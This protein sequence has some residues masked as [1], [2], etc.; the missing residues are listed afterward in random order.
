MTVHFVVRQVSSGPA[1]NVKYLM[2]RPL[3]LVTRKALMDRF[4]I[5]RRPPGGRT[6]KVRGEESR[7]GE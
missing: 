2:P 1:G 4:G 7:Q 6:G 3:P 5:D